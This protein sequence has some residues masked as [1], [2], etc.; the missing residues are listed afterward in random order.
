LLHER[1]PGIRFGYRMRT[2]S[3][4]F[5]KEEVETGALHR[6]MLNLP[7]PNASG[8]TWTTWDDGVSAPRLKPNDG[9]S[10]D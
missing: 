2:P 7:S 10:T 8:I 5:L 1:F 3:A 4:I 6:M 9:N